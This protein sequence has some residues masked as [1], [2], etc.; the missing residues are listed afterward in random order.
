MKR[1]TKDGLKRALL[2]AYRTA[3]RLFGLHVLPVHYYCPLP[4]PVELERSRKVWAHASEMKGIDVDLDRQLGDLRKVCLPVAHEYRGNA[5]YRY[6]S[7]HEFGPGYG[8]V[9][10]QALHG[11]IRHFKPRRIVEVG[12][13]VSTYCMREAAARNQQ[14]GIKTEI[15]AIEPNPSGA[16]RA[17]DGIRLAHQRVQETGYELF[18][19][20]EEND[21]LFIDSSHTVKA[22]GDV[23]FLILE[24]LPRLHEGVIVHFHD[25]YFPYD[26]PRDVLKTFYPALESSLLHAFLAFNSR[27]RIIF[28]LSLLHY[29]RPKELA[30]VFPEYQPQK[31]C[32]G[33][34]EP[35]VPA[36]STP[37]GYFPSSIYLRVD[38]AP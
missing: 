35:Q 34:V 27:F 32:D 11:V 1:W 7:S 22:G 12:S 9:E 31:D 19:A 33:L 38:R 18:E 6:A 15:I 2:S 29:G 8:Y 14:S 5:A 17:M 4:D 10:A 24:V 36:F 23:N 37:E 13:G 28:C 20:L 25:I 16:L 3:R 26:Y 21:L 30:E